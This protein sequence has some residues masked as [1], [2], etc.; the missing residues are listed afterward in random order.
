MKIFF[1][2]SLFLFFL[3]FFLKPNSGAA[4]C[5]LSDL[6]STYCVDAANVNLVNGTNY[7]GTGISGSTFSPATAGVGTHQIVTTN[8]SATSYFVSTS[9]TFAPLSSGS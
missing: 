6:N 2:F 9:G 5:S 7:Y 1:R 3:G 4:Q 8:G